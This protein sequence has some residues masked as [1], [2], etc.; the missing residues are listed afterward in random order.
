MKVNIKIK[1]HKHLRMERVLTLR[2]GYDPGFIVH[3]A[4]NRQMEGLFF[5]VENA[6]YISI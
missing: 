3:S 4:T 5:L 2:C 1:Y 6:T